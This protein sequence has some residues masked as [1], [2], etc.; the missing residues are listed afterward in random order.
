MARSYARFMPAG[1]ES[2]ADED[3]NDDGYGISTESHPREPAADPVGSQEEA[4]PPVEE[5][6]SGGRVSI[7]L[8]EEVRSAA[9]PSILGNIRAGGGGGGRLSAPFIVNSGLPLR[10]FTFHQIRGLNFT[11]WLYISADVK[12]SLDIDC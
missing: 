4:T 5:E 6:S 10:F 12:F 11:N 7:G 9:A 2:D 3:Y 8:A 1:Y